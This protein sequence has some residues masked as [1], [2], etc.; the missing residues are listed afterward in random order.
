MGVIR[1]ILHV[2]AKGINELSAQP[3]YIT[4]EYMSC[5]T[6]HREMWQPYSSLFEYGVRKML[7]AVRPSHTQTFSLVFDTRLNW[8]W[9]PCPYFLEF[10]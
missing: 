10:F 3:V 2:F 9:N 7:V 4:W 1:E 8:S 6:D 5:E